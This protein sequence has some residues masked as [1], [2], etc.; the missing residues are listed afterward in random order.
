[1]FELLEEDVSVCAQ[2]L[3]FVAEYIHVTCAL[4]NNPKLPE[5]GL[6]SF[7]EALEII[8][9]TN[10]FDFCIM[11]SFN[12]SKV[13]KQNSNSVAFVLYHKSPCMTSKIINYDE[14]ISCF[15]HINPMIRSSYINVQQIKWVI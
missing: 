11:L 5:D 10:G 9:C 1:M 13:S 12:H 2:L 6:T 15:R 4:M 7:V 8:I 3:C 14:N